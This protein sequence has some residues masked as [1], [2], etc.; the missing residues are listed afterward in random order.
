[1]KGKS[2]WFSIETLRQDNAFCLTVRKILMTSDERS[3]VHTLRRDFRRMAPDRKD[4][5]TPVFGW[6][7]NSRT[8]DHLLLSSWWPNLKIVRVTSDEGVHRAT[9]VKIYALKVF[10]S[11]IPCGLAA[12]T[13][14]QNWPI[15]QGRSAKFTS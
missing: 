15:A 7:E 8:R 6:E 2:E 3:R 4:I 10:G 5:W 14:H 11:V 12:A 13:P 9:V 1:M